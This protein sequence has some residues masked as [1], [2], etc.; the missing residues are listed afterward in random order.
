MTENNTPKQWK[1]FKEQLDILRQRGLVINDEQKAL[2][3]LRT[4]G[5][6][7]LSGY[8]YPFRQQ[9]P[10]E[11]TKKLDYFI[12]NTNFEDVKN[13]YIFDKKLRLLA[14]DALERI[15][16]ALRTNLV[17]QLGGYDPVA[18]KKA[19]Y[20]DEKFVDDLD[21]GLYPWLLKHHK[22]I[23]RNRKSNEA[24]KHNLEKYS[25]IPIWVVCEIWD[26]GTMV[27]LYGGLKEVD[28]NFIAQKYNLRNGNDLEV[29]LKALN[30]IRNISAH[31]SR[32][33]NKVMS[34]TIND[35]TLIGFNDENWLQ[36][37]KR[38]PFI[39]FCLMK[40]MLD[41]ICPN[42]SWQQRFISLLDE[43]PQTKNNAIS[44]ENM[45]MTINIVDWSI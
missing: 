29:L 41:I 37:P 10:N 5:Y 24:I 12:E 25:D 40:K 43:F 28:K 16:I 44:L 30:T 13:L 7:R 3:Y 9:D 18:Y 14:M 20:F 11:P 32:L 8:L 31:H 1:S 33:W 6:Y 39:Y 36:L 27:T 19:E 35:A 26:F 21:R 4:I 17:Y 15:E 45:G 22:Q 23:Q 34:T 42:S 38:K 2:K